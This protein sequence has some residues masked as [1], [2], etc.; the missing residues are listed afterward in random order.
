MAVEASKIA[1]N[2][3]IDSDPEEL[4]VINSLIVTAKALVKSSVDADMSD[5]AYEA[6]PLFDS[7]VEALVTAMYYDRTLQ[8]GMPKA[9]TIMVTH[10]QARIGG[11]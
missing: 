1:S 4:D 5:E 8:N 9:V 11:I 10:L 6:Y 2:L 7:A 3:H